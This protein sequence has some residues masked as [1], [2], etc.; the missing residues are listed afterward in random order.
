[1]FNGRTPRPA[2]SSQVADEAQ[3]EGA[4]AYDLPPQTAVFA[5]GPEPEEIA[6]IAA[7]LRQAAGLPKE[8]TGVVANNGKAKSNGSTRARGK[9]KASAR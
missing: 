7:K 3:P 2:R 4:P 9:S 6:E 8:P 5:P 1:M